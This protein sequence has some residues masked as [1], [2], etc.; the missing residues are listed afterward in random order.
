MVPSDR[1][2]IY[3]NVIIREPNAHSS[4]RHE[5]LYMYD[6]DKQRMKLSSKNLRLDAPGIEPGTFH[7]D[8]R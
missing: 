2:F 7:R 8:T 5:T 3:L 6:L 4:K 1:L